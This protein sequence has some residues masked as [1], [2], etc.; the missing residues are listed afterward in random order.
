[1]NIIKRYGR[2]LTHPVAGYN[3]LLERGECSL[4]LSLCFYALLVL[5]LIVNRELTGFAFSTG[6]AFSSWMMLL[7]VFGGAILWSLTNWAI[8]TLFDGKGRLKQ[9]LFFTAIATIPYTLSLLINTL[10][11][12]L[13][14]PD[15]GMFL[16]F[17]TGLGLLWG[18]LLLLVG[19]MLLHDYTLFRVIWSSLFSIACIAVVLFLAVLFY[20]LFMQL[21]GFL[22]DMGNELSYRM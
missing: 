3:D 10:L 16:G 9:I 22:A 20:S 8:S 21:Y 7:G 14:A 15:E 5:A 1:M 12:N 11:S 17:V 13:L 4:P 18:I 6:E 19:L 2:L